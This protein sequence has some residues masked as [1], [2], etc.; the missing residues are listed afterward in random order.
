[1]RQL[2]LP[3]PRVLGSR[4]PITVGMSVGYFQMTLEGLRGKLVTHWGVSGRFLVS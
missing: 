2:T 1:M 3:N 4:P